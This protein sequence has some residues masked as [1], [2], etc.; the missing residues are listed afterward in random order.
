MG[1]GVAFWLALVELVL[2]LEAS[3]AI[4]D[5]RVDIAV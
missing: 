2:S 4:G 5:V 3:E 1:A